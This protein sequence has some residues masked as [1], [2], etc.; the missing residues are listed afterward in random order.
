MKAELS[1]RESDYL[2]LEKALTITEE[3]ARLMVARQQEEREQTEEMMKAGGERIADLKT[4]IADLEKKNSVLSC[5]A[6]LTGIRPV[7]DEFL[8]EAL[9]KYAR[10]FFNIFCPVNY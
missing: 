6:G 4:E 2:R 7:A 9:F 10:I 1:A 5:R 3:S 8:K